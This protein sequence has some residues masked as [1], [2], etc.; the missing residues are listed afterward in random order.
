M[1][2]IELVSELVAN[3]KFGLSEKKE[4]VD[5]LFEIDVSIEESKAL[6]SQFITITEFI[7]EFNKIYPINQTRYKQRSDLYSL[8]DFLRFLNPNKDMVETICYYYRILLKIGPYIRPTQEECEPL[9]NYALNCVSQSNSKKA[10]QERQ[11]FFTDLFLNEGDEANQTQKAILDF[12]G[13]DH[14]DIITM[15]GK[16]TICLEAFPE[17]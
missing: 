9:M 7:S 14:S 17:S 1:N 4:K 3:L 10:R 11:T 6:R 15:S 2:D 16:K 8:F 12:F 13:M 5:V